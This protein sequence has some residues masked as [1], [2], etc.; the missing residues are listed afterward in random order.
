M[1]RLMTGKTQ[2]IVRRMS[3]IRDTPILRGSS[4]RVGVW[5]KAWLRR[6]RV[7][8]FELIVQYIETTMFLTQFV[9]FSLTPLELRVQLTRDC[10]TGAPYRVDGCGGAYHLSSSPFIVAVTPS[11]CAPRRVKFALIHAQVGLGS[12]SHTKS[13][14]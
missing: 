12:D 9:S 4:I 7:P 2:P 1:S 14:V 8:A 3:P 6:Y 5:D 11:T 13:F 10:V